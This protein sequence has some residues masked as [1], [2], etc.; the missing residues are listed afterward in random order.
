MKNDAEG[1]LLKIALFYRGF[2]GL[3]RLRGLETLF[4]Y[5]I[6]GSVNDG[7][8]DRGWRQSSR[9]SGGR[10]A[11]HF[12]EKAGK[13]GNAAKPYQEAGPGYRGAFLQKQFGIFHAYHGE[14]LIG[15]N[16]V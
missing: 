4:F 14:I 12:F 13:A 2:M 15:R 10:A 3:R 16:A 9:Y 5:I 1:Y 8:Y 11:G 7:S 6:G